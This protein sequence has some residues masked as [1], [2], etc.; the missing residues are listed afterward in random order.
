MKIEK[1]GSYH[2]N[3]I[4]N[5]GA[6][7]KKAT[8]NPYLPKLNY[9]STDTVCFTAKDKIK[10]LEPKLIKNLPP[11]TSPEEYSQI[12][13][14]IMTVKALNQETFWRY[15][16]EPVCYSSVPF[17]YIG[18][19]PYCG[20][21]DVSYYINHY[22][23]KCL[24]Q[25]LDS[26]ASEQD[27]CNI[28]RA[29]DYSLNRL[30]EQFGKYEGIVYRCGYFNPKS[31]QYASTSLSPEAAVKIQGFFDNTSDYSIIRTKNGHKIYDFQKMVNSPYA[32][33]EKEI[34]IDRNDISTY[35]LVSPEDYDDET[36]KA[37][38][39]LA[40]CLYNA[41]DISTIS[42]LPKKFSKKYKTILNKIKVY[43]QE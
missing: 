22:L 32:A 20:G 16:L 29:L 17:K 28:I 34:L 37:T 24:A 15:D 23:G 2:N 36:A 25:Y 31:K 1:Y 9:N 11:I 10:F 43:S 19:L 39:K 38:E 42:F 27:L 13:K 33:S 21:E 12:I 41:A 6:S 3:Y 35:K 14:R 7:Y 30:D 26:R 4:Y 40:A 8:S 18:L 5:T